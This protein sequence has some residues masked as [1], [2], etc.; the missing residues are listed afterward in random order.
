MTCAHCLRYSLGACRRDP[1]ARR[2]LPDP[3]FLRLGDGT[4]L[5]LEFDCAHCQ[6]LVVRP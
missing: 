6:M 3:L 5:R 4:R 2:Q 1:H